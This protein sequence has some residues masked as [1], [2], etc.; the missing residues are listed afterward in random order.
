M[1]QP[2]TNAGKVK[3]THIATGKVHLK[4]PETA[5]AILAAFK[6]SYK[7]ETIAN[8]PPELQEESKAKTKTTGA[9]ADNL[10]DDNTK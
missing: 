6:G 1:N 9:A 8:D 2:K 7:S 10:A 3:I 5:Q 4:D